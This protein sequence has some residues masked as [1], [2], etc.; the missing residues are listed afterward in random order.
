MTQAMMWPSS[1]KAKATRLERKLKEMK[2]LAIQEERRHDMR[3]ITG[4]TAE[5]GIIP[6]D[7]LPSNC[8]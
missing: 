6:L 3:S 4:G 2:E 1:A 7:A 5:P 8:K